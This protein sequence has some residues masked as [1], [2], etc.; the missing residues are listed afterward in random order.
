MGTRCCLGVDVSL[1]DPLS[2]QLDLGGRQRLASHR[3][4]RS[5]REAK[6]ALDQQA[7]TA[8]PGHDC[9]AGFSAAQDRGLGVKPQLAHDGIARVAL[10]AS[11]LENRGNV[12]LELNRAAALGRTRA[13][14]QQE[15]RGDAGRN[16]PAPV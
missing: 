5:I 11:L 13:R 7:F 16:H 4:S 14:R 6:D 3:H 2:D 12:P 15:K 9:G 10:S 8:I 1:I